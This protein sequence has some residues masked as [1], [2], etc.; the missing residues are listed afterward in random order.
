MTESQ[1]SYKKPDMKMHGQLTREMEDLFRGIEA[2]FK[3]RDALRAELLNINK[4]KLTFSPL[5]KQYQ[6]LEKE[7]EVWR[8]NYNVEVDKNG[9][10]NSCLTRNR[11]LTADL[12]QKYLR[13][14]DERD[15]LKAEMKEL[16]RFLDQQHIELG[17]W[18]KKWTKEQEKKIS[19]E[20]ESPKKE[21]D[22]SL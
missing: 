22:G 18:I 5:Y 7:C 12:H 13:L 1:D 14:L 19:E 21:P 17:G 8:R 16:D 20:T 11:E 3:D 6:E 2:I 9:T 10:L 15:Q 4:E